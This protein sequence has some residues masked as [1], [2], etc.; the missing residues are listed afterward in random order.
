MPNN[1]IKTL[2]P[3]E[4]IQDYVEIGA[5]KLVE[6][7]KP[8]IS[9][10]DPLGSE[11]PYVKTLVAAIKLPRTISDFILGKKV[12]AFLYAS[13]LSDA[14]IE[15]FKAKFSNVKQER[16]WEQVV[17]SINMHDDRK[18]TEIVGKLFNALIESLIS[19]EEFFTMLHATNSLNIHVLDVLKDFYMLGDNVSFSS[20]QYYSFVTNGLIDIDNS[21]IGTLGGGGPVYPPNQIGWKYI[22][23]VFDNPASSIDGYKIGETDLIVEYDANSQPTGKAYPLGYIKSKGAFYREADLFIVNDSGAILCD[24]QGFPIALESVI[25][26]AGESPERAMNRS[27]SIYDKTPYSVLLRKMEDINIQKWAFIIK[28][29]IIIKNTSFQ[30]ISDIHTTI[31]QFNPKTD[32]IRYLVQIVEQVERYVSGDLHDRWNDL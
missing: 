28:S 14:K 31:G 6:E 20:S 5:D 16:L 21:R 13:N 19:E 12:Y 10:L 1:N 25:P 26:I 22:G 9:M 29:N 3:S 4:L 24:E 32:Q 2:I 7:A 11:I 8:Y 17:F 30:S 18:K 15:K 27:A 23:I